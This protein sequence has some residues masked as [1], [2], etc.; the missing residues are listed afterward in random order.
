MIDRLQIQELQTL[1][2][3]DILDRLAT[4]IQFIPKSG[5]EHPND[6]YEKRNLERIFLSFSGQDAFQKIAFR[7][8][9]VSRLSD[10]EIRLLAG[11][12]GISTSLEFNQ[13]VEEISQK[14]W[15]DNNETKIFIDFFNL[16]DSYRPSPRQI[17]P[18][19]EKIIRPEAPYKS[20]KDFQVAIF[21][22]IMSSF[23]NP[24]QRIL[25][26]MPTGSGKT[27]TAM[28]IICSVLNQNPGKSVIWLANSEELCE[29]AVEC[30]KDVWSHIGTFNA[31]VIRAWGS[32]DVKCPINSSFIVAGF[33]KLNSKFKRNPEI[34]SLISSNLILIVIDEAH[35]VIAPTYRQVVSK[36]REN[37]F[38]IHMIGLTAT[39][40]RRNI[41]NEET[42]LLIQFFSGNRVDIDSGS[43]SVFEYL[44]NKKILA[45]IE[46][47]PLFTNISFELTKQ[48]REYLSTHYDFPL[49]FLERISLNDMRNIEIIKKLKRECELNKKILF[50][51]GSINQSKFICAILTFMGFKAEHIDG[52]TRR[53]RRRTIIRDFKDG[54]LNVI[55]NFGVLTTGFDAPK[56]DVVF[57][58]RPTMSIVLYSQMVGRGLRG[59]A[60]GGK[61]SCKLIDVI[62][63]ID[64]YQSPDNV[65]E[66]FGEYWEHN[67]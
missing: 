21:N 63:N 30:F 34:A 60:I 52:S 24:L 49:E 12:M 5:V 22:K 44:R 39:P 29:Q 56:T 43:R 20:L 25:I 38:N 18:N 35:Q 17:I 28:E 65:Y 33:S 7:E 10:R 19:I 51:A 67:E 11:K 40:G 41:E 1:I 64:A 59:P 15:L 58:A 6:I 8:K 55:C 45:N 61:S 37:N 46:K 66:Y 57:I 3:E 32:N 54:D 9:L 53:D 27:R 16:P 13:L 23:E 50:F 62:D 31:D 47:D 48:E 2:G 42:Y 4:I 36:L 26:Q 14:P